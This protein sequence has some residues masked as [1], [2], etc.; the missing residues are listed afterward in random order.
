MLSFDEVEAAADRLPEELQLRL[1]THLAARLSIAAPTV[2]DSS[3]NVVPRITVSE[4]RG[5]SVLDIP[6]YSVG[7]IL[8]PFSSE[9]DRM[10]DLFEDRNYGL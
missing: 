6:S 4:K 5:H 1:F 9:D 7:P 10:D 2:T 3:T 8:R